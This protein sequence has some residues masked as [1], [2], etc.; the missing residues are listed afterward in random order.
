MREEYHWHTNKKRRV[1][2]RQLYVTRLLA[3]KSDQLHGVRACKRG[4]PNKTFDE[5]ITHA[6]S[7]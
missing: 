1:K 6:W 2:K 7:V 4:I 5:N 3:F